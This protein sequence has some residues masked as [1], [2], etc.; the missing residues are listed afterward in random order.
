[1]QCIEDVPT[2]DVQLIVIGILF[3]IFGIV[4]VI[5]F[6]MVILLSIRG[7]Q[8]RRHLLHNESTKDYA[9]YF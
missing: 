4:V 6:F 3:A 8:Q 7:Y 5:V 9:A 2:P 1:M